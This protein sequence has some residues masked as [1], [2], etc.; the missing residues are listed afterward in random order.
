MSQ[1]AARQEVAIG[2][3]E[4]VAAEVGGWPGVELAPHRFGGTEFR[5]GK[6]ELGHLHGDVLAD[7]P[8]PRRVRDELVA[9]GSA[10]PHHVLPDSGW[11]SFRIESPGDVEHAIALFRLAY[12]RAS[13]ASARTRRRLDGR[14]G[15]G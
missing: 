4:R 1:R 3:R 12:E 9:E 11:V 5:L 6:R 10:Q 2:A 7:L 8:F 15:G 13:D 14:G